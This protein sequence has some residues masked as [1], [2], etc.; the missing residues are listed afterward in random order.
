[1][2]AAGRC[3]R[4]CA[5]RSL[6]AACP[7]SCSR[8]AESAPAGAP[9]TTTTTFPCERQPGEVVALRVASASARIPR[10]RSRP[11]AMR[12]VGGTPGAQVDQ[13]HDLVRPITIGR[14][15]PSFFDRDARP[16][17][18]HLLLHRHALRESAVARRLEPELL[19][20]ASTRKRIARVASSVPVSRPRIESSANAYR[21][22]R[23]S[24]AVTAPIGRRGRRRCGHR[25][26]WR[27]AA[28]SERVS[29]ATTA[30]RIEELRVV[31]A[32]R[33]ARRTRIACVTA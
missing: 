2:T 19:S 31:H 21:S 6:I 10:T 22:R 4:I 5:S 24:S 20:R 11:S 23:S 18:E 8:C 30:R 29:R 15:R 13:R 17:S 1:M 9:F 3:G 7:S 16:G 25:A 12:F 27:G 28:D 14:T 33:A 26:R 32:S